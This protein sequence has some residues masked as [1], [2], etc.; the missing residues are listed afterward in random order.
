M[1][2][3]LIDGKIPRQLYIKVVKKVKAISSCPIF[4]TKQVM[5]KSIICNA[6][7][8]CRYVEGKIYA[9]NKKDQRILMN[10]MEKK[11]VIKIINKKF[12][13]VL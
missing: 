7:A 11:G 6:I 3:R 12:V 8:H 5:K 1:I 13:K 9:I 10:E 4:G 2:S